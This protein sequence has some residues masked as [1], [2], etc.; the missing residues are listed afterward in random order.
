MGAAAIAQLLEQTRRS[1]QEMRADRDDLPEIEA[2]GEAETAGGLVRAVVT[3]EAHLEVL[4]LD[5]RA[6]RMDSLALSEEIVR[7]VNAAA[8]ELRAQH[9]QGP[10]GAPDPQALA[11][12]LEQ[13]QEESVRRMAVF[14]TAM[15]DVLDRLAQ[16][17]GRR[18]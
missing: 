3:P 10:A 16:G 5:P 8:D 1:L 2:R 17:D 14:S 18:G 13:V 15:A 6:M 9:P 4:Y 7:A 11:E 12:Q